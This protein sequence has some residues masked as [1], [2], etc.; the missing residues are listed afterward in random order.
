MSKGLQDLIIKIHQIRI[1]WVLRAATQRPSPHPS[2]QAG[3]LTNQAGAQEM[4]DQAQT[5]QAG[6]LIDQAQALISRGEMWK[7]A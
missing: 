6:R 2:R 4:I 1:F 5:R 3:R 7:T